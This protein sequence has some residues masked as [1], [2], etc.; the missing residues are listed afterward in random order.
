MERRIARAGFSALRLRRRRDLKRKL[1]TPLQIRSL[2]T[3]S[4]L[5]ITIPI[6][7]NAGFSKECLDT[8]PV[9][10]KE[11]VGDRCRLT[12]RLQLK[13][14]RESRGV[15]W[16]NWWQEYVVF[17]SPAQLHLLLLH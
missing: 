11:S 3:K 4:T 8:D 17:V 7:N 12:N 14:M 5:C 2:G 6:E 1:H 15:D 16:C 9:L 13:N 10:L